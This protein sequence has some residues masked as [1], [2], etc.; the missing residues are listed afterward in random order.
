MV[1]YR[2][3]DEDRDRMSVM[4]S[5]HGWLFSINR[6]RNGADQGDQYEDTQDCP[7]SSGVGE[8]CSIRHHGRIAANFRF[9]RIGKDSQYSLSFK[10]GYRKSNYG[11]VCYVTLSD[12]DDSTRL[13]RYGGVQRTQAFDVGVA[14]IEGQI[15]TSLAVGKYTD[16]DYIN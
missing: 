4:L 8:G 9:G 3:D 15:E 16:V 14:R 7:D 5:S 12:R 13:D 11:Y 6:D 10:V 2:E 1:E